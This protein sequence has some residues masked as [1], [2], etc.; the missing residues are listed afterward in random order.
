MAMALQTGLG[1]IWDKINERCPLN[2]HARK[3]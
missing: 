2:A 1:S 3:N